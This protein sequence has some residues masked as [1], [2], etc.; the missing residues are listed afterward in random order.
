MS[1]LQERLRHIADGGDDS[2]SEG[3]LMYLAADALDRLEAR[4][5]GLESALR[6]LFNLQPTQESSTNATYWA[7]VQKAR[8]AL[9]AQS[10]EAKAHPL[11]K[12]E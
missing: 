7:A 11:S 3:N 10:G 8:A 2:L 5:A 6:G 9:A 12:E 1:T 4:I